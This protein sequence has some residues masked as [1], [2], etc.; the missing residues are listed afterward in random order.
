MNVSLAV[1]F[2]SV[3]EKKEQYLL[4]AVK[5]DAVYYWTRAGIANVATVS[6]L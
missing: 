4:I 1:G 3:L 5:I 6:D 2:L